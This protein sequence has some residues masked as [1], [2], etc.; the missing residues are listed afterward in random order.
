MF[1]ATL[2]LFTL[3]NLSF[4]QTPLKRYNTDPNQVSYSGISAG[5][6]MATQMHVAYSSETVGVGLMATPGPYY[7]A[8]GNLFTALNTCMGFPNGI[9]VEDCITETE[10]FAR[11]GRI[12]PTSN[13]RNDKVFILHG[14]ED[15]TVGI[16]AAAKV[17]QYYEH[18]GATIAEE[19]SLSLGH[20]VPTTNYGI[21]CPDTSSPYL[22][23]CNY[24]GAFSLLKHIYPD[25]I[26]PSTNHQ[27]TGKLLRY[28]QEEFQK[29]PNDHSFDDDGFVYVP[30]ACELEMN[31]LF[32]QNECEIPVG[33]RKKCGFD[34]ITEEQCIVNRG[35]CWRPDGPFNCFEKATADKCAVSANDREECGFSGINQTICENDRNCCWK[36]EQPYYCFRPKS[37]G[38]TPGGKCKVHMVFH[39]CLQGNEMVGEEFVRNAGYNEIADV[40]NI[41]VLY[42]EVVSNVMLGNMNGC[43]DWWGY[44]DENYAVKDGEQ[45]LAV[46]K[47]IQRVLGQD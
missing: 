45:M 31:D 39:G 3:V 47:M 12:D 33:D 1:R 43:Y 9:Y 46:Y 34:S 22:N 42:P 37:G 27:L 11:E 44:E 41:V 20:G 18:Y 7:C 40:N 17:R 36:E 19:L 24:D 35:C 5:A 10:N 23:K 15:P 32:A 21:S 4:S 8:E 30:A 29:D 16:D 13:L 28:D 14:K 38:P 26:K 2:V 6:A 25:I